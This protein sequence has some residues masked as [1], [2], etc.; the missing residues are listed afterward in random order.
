MMQEPIVVDPRIY[1]I[2]R[3]SFD[4]VDTNHSN[5]ID[6]N[7]LSLALAKFAALYGNPPPNQTEVFESFEFLDKNKDGQI[8]FEEYLDY[9]KLVYYGIPLP[10]VYVIRRHII[11]VK[12]PV[13]VPIPMPMPQP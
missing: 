6:I 3:S 11:Q 9:I 7:E 12:V 10:T 5:T 2:A 1:E 13:P 8:E 4:E